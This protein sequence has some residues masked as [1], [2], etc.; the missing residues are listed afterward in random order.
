MNLTNRHLSCI[1]RKTIQEEQFE[2]FEVTMGLEGDV[3]DDIDINTEFIE[4]EKFL[5]DKVFT[6]IYNL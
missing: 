2:P 5:E 6:V 4:I 3:P 1:V